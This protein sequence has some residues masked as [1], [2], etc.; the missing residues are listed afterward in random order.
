MSANVNTTK[1]AFA[2]GIAEQVRASNTINVNDNFIEQLQ[3]STV[4]LCGYCAVI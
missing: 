2:L 3:H 4:G 1:L